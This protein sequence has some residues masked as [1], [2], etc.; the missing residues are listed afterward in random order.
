MITAKE[1]RTVAENLL[2]ANTEQTIK[3]LDSL[4][5]GAAKQGRMYVTV[6]DSLVEGLSVT[7]ALA[8]NGY[9]VSLPSNRKVTISWTR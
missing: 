5:R 2:R 3:E 7:F 4:I 9:H 8:S 6:D 1:A